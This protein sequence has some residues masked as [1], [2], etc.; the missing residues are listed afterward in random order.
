MY[1][2]L[3][4]SAD[5]V[6]VNCRVQ[7]ESEMTLYTAHLYT[8]ALLCTACNGCVFCA[9]N[10]SEPHLKGF[11]GSPYW[12]LIGNYCIYMYSTYVVPYNMYST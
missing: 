9:G 1:C 5:T 8:Y 12:N 2:T 10:L 3:P 6:A 4:Q 7:V 11:L